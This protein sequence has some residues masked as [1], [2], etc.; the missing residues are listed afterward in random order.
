MDKTTYLFKY[1]YRLWGMVGRLA[2]E[3]GS[4]LAIPSADF[5]DSDPVCCSP[6]LLKDL[7]KRAGRGKNG[8]SYKAYDDD[9]YLYYVSH[10]PEGYIIWG[11]VVFEEHSEH[12]KQA[13]CEKY[14]VQGKN[15]LIPLVD[16]WRY[17]EFITFAHGLLFE[18]YELAAVFDDEIGSERFQGTIYPKILE[19]GLE[20]AEYGIEHHS[21]VDEQKVY[22]WLIEGE[23]PAGGENVFQDEMARTF[24]NLPGAV[25]IMAKSQRKNVEYGVVAGITLA[26]RYAIAAGVRE[27]EAYALSDVTLQTLARTKSTVEMYDTMN[28]AFQEFSRLGREAKTRATKH[29]LYVEQSKDYI[30][31][32]IYEKL[33]LQTVADKVGVHKVYL[34]RIFSEQMG[35]T[36]TDYIMKEKIQISCNLL[37]YSNRPIAIVAEYINLSP[38]SYFTRVFKKVTGETPAQYRQTHIDKNFIES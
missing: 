12:E 18:E 23:L 22:K 1:M 20:N 27:S 5:R 32:H 11:P 17:K 16:V 4:L 9:G 30:A 21:F 13:Y 36:L 38:Q 26:T 33:S 34:S 2:D 8:N 14:G 28:H 3:E 31:K 6:A 24:V 15:L 10:R 37:K 35:M 19:Y 25:G 29:S 7:Q